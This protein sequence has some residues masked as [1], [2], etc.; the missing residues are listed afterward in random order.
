LSAPTTTANGRGYGASHGAVKLLMAGSTVAELKKRCTKK[1]GKDDL[2][3][4]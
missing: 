1:R 4:A 2:A 3:S